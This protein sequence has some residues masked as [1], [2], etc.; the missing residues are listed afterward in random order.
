M[1]DD[2]KTRWRIIYEVIYYLCI[3][4]GNYFTTEFFQQCKLNVNIPKSLPSDI[5]NKI[6]AIS[7]EG[8]L[9]SQVVMIRRY[10]MKTRVIK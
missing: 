3:T 10:I 5:K 8:G 4:T 9:Y 6:K 2:G 1:K 7:I